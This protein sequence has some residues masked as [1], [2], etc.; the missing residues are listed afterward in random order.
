MNILLALDAEGDEE[1]DPM[2]QQESEDAEHMQKNEPLI[3]ELTPPYA[4]DA[5]ETRFPRNIH[6]RATQTQSSRLHQ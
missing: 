2:R 1:R 4:D 6:A 3:P 5:G